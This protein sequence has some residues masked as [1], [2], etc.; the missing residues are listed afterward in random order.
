MEDVAGLLFK[1]KQ[2]KIIAL[3]S[4]PDKE[5]TIGELAKESGSTYVH[6]SRFIVA[7]EDAGII[8]AEIIGRSKKI[9]LTEK[10]KKISV[11]L[12]DLLVAMAAPNEKAQPQPVIQKPTVV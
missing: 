10:G 2:A 4:R 11:T 1:P 6:A 8:Q 9:S 12:A 7:C 3:L 5:W